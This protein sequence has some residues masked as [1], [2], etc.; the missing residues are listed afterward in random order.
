[1]N[2]G[3]LIPIASQEMIRRKLDWCKSIESVEVKTEQEYLNACE[4]TKLI[5]AGIKEL[6]EDRHILVDP[7]KAEAKEIDAAYK[8]PIDAM[9]NLENRIGRAIGS[10]HAELQRIAAEK[11]RAIEDQMQKDKADLLKEAKI[12]GNFELAHAAQSLRTPTV[13]EEIPKTPS[14]SFR[15]YWRAEITNLSA[16]VA[17]CLAGQ[18]FQYLSPNQS[19]LDKFAGA[20]EGKTPIPGVVFKSEQ[21]PVGR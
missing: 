10:Y 7:I 3:M 11:Q 8:E 13:K 12:T 6:D 19:T 21:R 9:K 15:T 4:L 20:T 18:E 2:E 5:K 14:L 17:W 16:F 1:M